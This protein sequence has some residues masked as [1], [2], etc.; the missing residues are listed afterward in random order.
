MVLL[1]RRNYEERKY[2][3][4]VSEVH[5]AVESFIIRAQKKSVKTSKY[6]PKGL[7]SGGGGGGGGG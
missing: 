3:G 4:E 5:V 7:F 2:M 6:Q 1:I